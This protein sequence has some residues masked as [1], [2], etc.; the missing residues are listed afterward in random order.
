MT[1][2]GPVHDRPPAGPRTPGPGPSRRRVRLV[3]RK[4]P[5]RPHWEHEGE[6]LGED[7]H[8]VWVGA[9]VGTLLS[10]PGASL[11]TD[12]AQVTL[13]PRD[14]P[15]VATFY[16]PGGLAHC[17][18]Y[19]DIAT[20]PRWVA[21]PDVDVVTAVDLDLDVVRGWSG[22]VWVEDED[23]FA[24]HRVRYAYPGDVVR[25]AATSCEAVRVAVEQGRAP[26]DGTAST[27]FAALDGARASG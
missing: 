13:V 3:A 1:V 8:G 17:D 21:G 5:D 19:V 23:E 18:V 9:R 15:F 2:G 25:L 11:V 12:Q 26:Y 10:R 27:W 7:Q 22:R 4:W 16:A 6:H 14:E 24:A 20:V